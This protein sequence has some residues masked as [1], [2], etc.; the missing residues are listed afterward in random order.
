MSAPLAAGRSIPRVPHAK[1]HAMTTVL[2]R[3]LVAAA[4][5]LVLGAGSTQAATPKLAADALV[6]P[7]G[8][9]LVVTMP[10][11]TE[12]VRKLVVTIL[13][14]ST[15]G[16]PKNRVVAFTDVAVVKGRATVA[17]G[18]APR[19]SDIRFDA[20]YGDG[21]VEVPRSGNAI[22]RLRPDLRVVAVHAPPQTLN[23][24][25]V[26]VVV[27]LEET[28]EDSSVSATLTL[29]QGG[30]PVTAS[31][32]VELGVG[33]TAS[34]VF[35]GVLLGTA[36]RAELTARIE[37]AEP[38]EF[39]GSNNEGTTEIDVTEHEL[40]R[41]NVLVPSL[42]GYGAQ[43]NNHVYAPITP[44]PAGTSHD[45]FEAKVKALQPHI[46]RI[47]YNDNWDGNRDGRFPSPIWE[48][49]YASFVKTV[50]LAQDSG[51]IIDISFQN[52]ANARFT[53]IPDMKKFADVLEDLVRNHELTNVRFAEV[54]NEPNSGG[55]AAVSLAEYET[56]VRT[57]DAELRARGLRDHIKM[58]GPGLIENAG[59]PTRTHYVWMKH[60]AANMG[61]VLDAWGQ[62]VYWFYND[63]GRLEYRLRDVWHLLNEVIPPE[64]RK[65]TYMMEYGARGL[66]NC[67]GQP[68]SRN[69]YYVVDPSCPA[70]QRTNIA[71]F[72]QFWFAV[73][74]A[75][76]GYVGAAKWDAY[77]GV[78]DFTLS[79][80][81]VYWTIGPAAEGSPLMPSY[82]SLTL[83]FHTTVPGWQVVGMAP[84]DESDWKVS[85]YG[86]EGHSSSDT[87]EKEL[88]AYAGPDGELT[89]LGL[90]TN[91]RALNGLSA[92]PPPQYSIGG[93][94]ASTTFTLAVWN[95]AGDGKN[96]IAA[97]VTTN[98]AGVARFEV[99]LHA[100]F[101]LT[102]LPVS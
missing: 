81:Q 15:T 99:P 29:L 55:T 17:L 85:T 88:A 56:L 61:D 2:R 49:N 44:W 64:Q 87:R 31:K 3:S 28:L 67:A 70:I 35:E 39:D 89:I 32:T 16:R 24:R 77:W 86:I 40:V 1:E 82:H 54:G 62:H 6:G 83:L 47:F 11:G 27:D 91:G 68:L 97:T 66:D 92:E 14:P 69:T 60:I 4:F 74:S 43:F 75:Q 58:M 42:A 71:G 8:T 59:V 50:R 12:S 73:A 19:G 38:A 98:A 95:A 18:D 10:P 21:S 78:Y 30:V 94:P 34:P 84:W 63:T 100:A 26:D 96:T 52:L 37:L 101:S 36:S 79:P 22:A 25:R 23:T 80:P 45:D 51:A 41:S 13:S 5:A 93:L 53:P 33:G 65:P 90:D 9:D 20:A 7:A 46:V 76:L 57:L 48:Q 72:Q 102:T